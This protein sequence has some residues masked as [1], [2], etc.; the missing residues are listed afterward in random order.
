MKFAVVVFPGSNCDRDMYHAVKDG[1]GQEADLV[2]YQEANLADYDAILLPGG[3]SYGDYLRSGAI[4]S[5]AP[6]VEQIREAAEAGK[7]ILGVCNGF[8]VL[9]EMGLLPG[10]MLANERL[11]FMCHYE[12]LTVENADT[13][14]THH[15]E[16]KAKI[17]IPIA[18]GEGNY[19]C[20]EETYAKL[21]EN[22][23][24]VFTY[25]ENPN[26]SVGDIAGI[27]NEQ[28]NVLGMMPHPERAVEALLGSDDGLRLFES[29][30]TH[31]R[32]HHAI[33]A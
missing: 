8:Q 20:D 2:W 31:W 27:M 6:I 13:L 28:G 1:L 7:P 19:Y 26:G 18:H 24:I 4:A 9:L 14:F 21:R 15:Y 3:F 23:Q 30:L 22:N 11:K 29:I 16:E 32:E 33:N 5:T 17:Q 12:T 10:A 25:E